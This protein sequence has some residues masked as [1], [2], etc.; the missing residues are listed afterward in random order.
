MTM[1]NLETLEDFNEIVKPYLEKHPNIDLSDLLYRV[2]SYS[3]EKNGVPLLMK[4]DTMFI[5]TIEEYLKQTD[6][7][8]DE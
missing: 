1:T 2:E 4:N 6:E 5:W 7:Q 8:T 3:L